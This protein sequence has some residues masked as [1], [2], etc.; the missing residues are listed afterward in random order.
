[1]RYLWLTRVAPYPPH[2]SGDVAYARGLIE[3]LAAFAQVQVVCL[4][5][6]DVVLPKLENIDWT[7]VDHAPT[8]RQASIASVLPH[9][10]RQNVSR[11]YLAAALAAAHGSD[12]IVVDNLA[13]AWCVQPLLRRL[14]GGCPPL[15]M[16]NHN[17]ETA[18]RP[19]LR[20]AASSR[21]MKTVLAWDGWKAARLER[22]VNRAA[23][24]YTAITSTDLDAFHALAPGKPS[25]LLMPGYDGRRTSGRVISN[26]TPRRVSIIGGRGTFYKKMVLTNLL[27]VL[28]A[29]GLEDQLIIDVV[30]GG[31]DTE[32]AQL[33][34]TFPGFRFIGFVEDLPAYLETSR[35]GIVADSIGGGFKIRALNHVFLRLPMLA[36]DTALEGMQLR[37]GIDYIPVSTLADIPARLMAVVDD[38]DLLNR[39]HEA[40][41]AHYAPMFDW[42]DRMQAF[43]AFAQ[44]VRRTQPA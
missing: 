30:G 2:K 1:M 24:A 13:M 38:N 29:Q 28:Q 15:I 16:V 11:T 31:L 41:Y 36:L 40:A 32:L 9:V 35:L 26:R 22:A 21:L 4:K 14:G 25:H 37:S 43:H 23:D 42:Q 7:E 8:S 18:M 17:F 3:H 20:A 10:A 12:V 6:A 27:R 33:Q 44:E 34:A 5:T 39:T 19:G